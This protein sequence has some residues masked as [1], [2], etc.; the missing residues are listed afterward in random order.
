MPAT[1]LDYLTT[2]HSIYLHLL[3][4]HHRF[5]PPPAILIHSP[6]HALWRRRF[7]FLLGGDLLDAFRRLPVLRSAAPAWNLVSRLRMCRLRRG[8]EPLIRAGNCL[9]R[10]SYAEHL[11]LP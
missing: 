5:S 6:T 8:V 7:R 2:C 10:L 9:P 4:P 1:A 11:P 3:L